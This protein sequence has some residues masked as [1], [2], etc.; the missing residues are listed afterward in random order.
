[1]AY[2]REQQSA[3]KTF[4]TITDFFMSTTACLNRT[5]TTVHV[6]VLF[7]KNNYTLVRLILD[8]VS[9]KID[10][11]KIVLTDMANRKMRHDAND[12]MIIIPYSMIRITR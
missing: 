2:I 10:G 9:I 5:N 12:Q 6:V 4:N 3:S 7:L 8:D 1:M 11:K